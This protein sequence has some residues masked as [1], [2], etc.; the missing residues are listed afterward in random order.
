MGNKI[1]L[2]FAGFDEMLKK[3]AAAEA[4]TKR[5]T[6]DAIKASFDIVTAAAE[7]SVQPQ[8]LPAHGKYSSGRTAAS[9]IRDCRVTWDGTTATAPVGFD[10]SHGGLPSIFMI[11]GSPR[12][13]KNQLMYDAFYG[14]RIRGEVL[15]A[16]LAIFTRVIGEA[17]A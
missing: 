3:L 11:R 5:V 7:V 4:D 12:Y 17:M 13:M 15:A 1:G 10:A 2:E 9:L 14:E 16:Q 6:E 8:N